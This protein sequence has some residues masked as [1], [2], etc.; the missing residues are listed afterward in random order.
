MP[1]WPRSCWSM[2][3]AAQLLA[4]ELHR[5]EGSAW[6]GPR[7]AAG[8]PSSTALG[9]RPRDPRRA[10]RPRPLRRHSEHTQDGEAD[11]QLVARLDGDA[12]CP[13]ARAAPLRTGSPCVEPS[14]VAAPPACDRSA[15][16]AGSRS[17]ASLTFMSS[18]RI[19]AVGAG[20]RSCTH[21]A[22]REAPRR[23]RV[24]TVLDAKSEGHTWVSVADS[25]DSPARGEART[26]PIINA[27]GRRPGLPGPRLHLLPRR[28]RSRRSCP[29][30]DRAAQPDPRSPRRTALIT[31]LP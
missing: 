19:E 10:A 22:A 8:G 17:A 26:A 5:P 30:R 23:T 28:S 13:S 31:D 15:G 12:S 7:H 1:P 11:A 25:A 6:C 9:A 24:L 27:I 2:V 29:W 16:R 4:D 3:V 21:P 14:V 20:G 18:T